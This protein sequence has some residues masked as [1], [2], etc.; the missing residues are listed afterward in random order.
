MEQV[1]L[2][3]FLKAKIRDIK[4]TGAHLEYEGS[5]TL[6]ENYIEQAGILPYEEVHVLNLENGNRFTTYVIKGKRGT[7]VVELNGPAALLGKVG[8]RIM[9]VAF[10]YLTENEIPFHSPLVISGNN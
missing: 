7:G 10:A 3:S 6:D 5:I 8:N 4:V 2:R 9:V 1:M